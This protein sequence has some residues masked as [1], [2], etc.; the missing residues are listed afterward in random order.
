MV[1]EHGT[2]SLYYGKPSVYAAQTGIRV[3]KTHHRCV[4]E[5][6]VVWTSGLND[7]TRGFSERTEWTRCSVAYRPILHSRFGFG[8]PAGMF[9]ASGTASVFLLFPVWPL[10]TADCCGEGKKASFIWRTLTHTAV[11]ETCYHR[12]RF[13]GNAVYHFLSVRVCLG[14]RFVWSDCRRERER[15]SEENTHRSCYQSTHM[16][17]WTKTRSIRR[18]QICLLVVFEW[19]FL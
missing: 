8:F 15:S 12:Q 5:V 10:T 9:S 11:H 19:S 18:R 16:S 2:S 6:V 1:S 13:T 3:C 14:L 4:C 17:V 7:D